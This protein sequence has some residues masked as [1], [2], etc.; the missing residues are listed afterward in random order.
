MSMI[1][2]NYLLST[3]EAEAGR[4]AEVQGQSRICN[5]D[6]VNSA[7]KQIPPSKTKTKQGTQSC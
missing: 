3:W 1:A 5:Q 6:K 4:L 2:S 7:T